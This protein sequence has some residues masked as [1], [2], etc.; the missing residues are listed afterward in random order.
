MGCIFY[1]A[2]IS[3]YKNIL[4]SLVDFLYKNICYE[5]HISKIILG[6]ATT[7]IMPLLHSSFDSSTQMK[8]EFH[9][10]M[11]KEINMF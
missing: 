4:K 5:S 2:N 9:R 7:Q 3:E 10:F 1:L 8:D 11:G 6:G